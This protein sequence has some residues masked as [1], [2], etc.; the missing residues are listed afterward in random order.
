MSLMIDRF[1]GHKGDNMQDLQGKLIRVRDK[2]EKMIDH[3]FL[4]HNIERPEIDEEKLLLLLSILDYA[5]LPTDDLENYSIATML[6]QLALDTHENVTNAPMNE[7]NQRNIQL[8]VLAGTYYS[9]LFYQIL[10]KKHEVHLIRKLAEG[11]EIINDQKILVYLKDVDGIEELMEGV[12]K[13]EASLLRKLTAY[14]QITNLDDIIT[15]FLLIKRLLAEKKKFR[16]A[17]SSVVFDALR[18][19]VFPK[20]DQSLMELSIEQKN[21]LVHICDR[22]IEF[23]KD[24]LRKAKDKIPFLNEDLERR[25]SSILEQHQPVAK[26]LA[27][28]G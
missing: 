18:K 19:L 1:W 9:G 15:N 8:T 2:M 12:K 20:N 4:S 13:I 3:P 26:S 23:S 6:L 25:F 14:F 7:D 24:L 28:E 11:T 5:K 27:E 17:C 10:A 22:Y 21:H 16:E